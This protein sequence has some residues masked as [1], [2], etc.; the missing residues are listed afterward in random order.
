MKKFYNKLKNLLNFSNKNE[1]LN[2]YIWFYEDERL[3]QDF[4]NCINE[5]KITKKSEV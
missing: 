1:E 2:Y 4:L 5:Y 3:A